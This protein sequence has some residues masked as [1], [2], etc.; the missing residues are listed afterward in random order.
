M[1]AGKDYDAILTNA[2]NSIQL[3]VED[4]LAAQ[5]DAR[6][7]LSGV[8]NIYAGVLLLCKEVL[9][10]ASPD[11]AQLLY[12]HHF[13]PRKN[14]DGSVSFSPRAVKPGKRRKT[15]DRE[16]IK[17]YF[18]SLGLNLNTRRL[19]ELSAIRNDIEHYSPQQGAKQLR[20]AIASAFVLI[21]DV[22]SE[23]FD[24]EPVDLLGKHCWAN[25]EKARGEEAEERSHCNRSLAALKLALTHDVAKKAIDNIRCP[26]C[27]STFLTQT[28]YANGDWQ[29]ATF[30][31]RDCEIEHDSDT[32]AQI[33]K[34]AIEELYPYWPP[35]GEEP[36]TVECPECSG[37]FVFELGACVLCDLEFEGECEF[38]SEALTLD[39]YSE[40]D[41]LCSYCRHK[42]TKLMAE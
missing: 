29:A 37:V 12:E 33:L 18:A 7:S 16:G 9:R 21:R 15:I 31:C 41:G 26:S 30:R 23:H 1:A 32:S 39:D 28:E 8:R 42:I 13:L 22:L 35:D 20:A 5:K 34:S 27:E 25:I 38:C 24:H 4:Y 14:D 36:T 19:D 2:V 3:G 40:D 17:A 6:R 11:D 10:E